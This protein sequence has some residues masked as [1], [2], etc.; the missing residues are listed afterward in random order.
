M[1]QSFSAIIIDSSQSS[2]KTLAAVIR[3]QF[4][5]KDVYSASSAREAIAAIRQVEKLD[6]IFCDNQLSDEDAFDFLEQTKKIKST[7]DSKIILLS[8]DGGKEALML[9]ATHGVNDIILK[10]FTPKVI[11]EKVRKLVGSQNKRSSKRISLLE[12]FEATIEFKDGKYKSA[13]IDISLGGCMAK[14]PL[15]S[16]GGMIYDKAIIKIPLEK[17]EIKLKAELI[18]LERDNST[19]ASILLAAF[20]FDKM[21]PE[22]AKILSNFLSTMKSGKN[23][24]KRK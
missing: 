9:A 24:S 15:F 14:T 6:W 7:A 18:R 16:K 10:P 2:R 23:G 11:Q 20:I 1:Q 8:A 5:M 3:Q 19:E 17:E 13:L 4:T 21:S 12:A 22:A